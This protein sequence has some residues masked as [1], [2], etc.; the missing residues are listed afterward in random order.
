MGAEGYDEADEAGRPIGLPQNNSSGLFTVQL[1]IEGSVHDVY[2]YPGTT[3]RSLIT[4]AGVTDIHNFRVELK[5]AHA[6]NLELEVLP[7]DVFVLLRSG[8]SNP[9]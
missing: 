4:E 9:T 3:I 2:V 8:T 1:C 6:H 7:D 5:G